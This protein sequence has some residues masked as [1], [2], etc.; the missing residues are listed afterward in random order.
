MKYFFDTEFHERIKKPWFGK[1][2]HLM[3]LISIGI[4][5]EDGRTYSAVSSD[6]DLKAA[7]DNEW[8]RENVL[9][10]IYRE[11]RDIQNENTAERILYGHLWGWF[12]YKS[13][14]LL[15]SW[16]GKKNDQIAAEIFDFINPNLGFHIKNYNKINE[17][18]EHFTKHNVTVIK[19]HYY[20]QPEFYAYFADYD[21]VLLC[22]LFGSMMDLPP[23]FPMYCKDLKQYKDQAIE[24]AGC[25]FEGADTKEAKMIAFEA[26]KDYPLNYNSHNALSDAKWNYKI[27][28]FLKTNFFLHV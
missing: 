25:Y 3:E 11:L 5:D 9:Y 24:K 6:F 7:W 16:H 22:S 8:L 15:I 17:R 18:M 1:K 26:L 13:L 19:D 14:K 27:Y 12:S 4:V 28:N 2:Y 23:G 10:P 21:W 20:A